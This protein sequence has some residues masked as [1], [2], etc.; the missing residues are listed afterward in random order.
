MVF[1][2]EKIREVIEFEVSRG[3]Q[4]FFIHNR[5]KD[6]QEVGAMILSLVPT[7][8]IT[9]AHGQLE[10]HVLEEKND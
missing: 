10:G 6:I 2:P 5:V 8:S 4:V 1:D 3:G 9:I 7:I